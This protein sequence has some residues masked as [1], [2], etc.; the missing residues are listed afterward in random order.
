MHLRKLIVVFYAGKE[1]ICKELVVYN[2]RRIDVPS[3]KFWRLQSGFDSLNYELRSA[4]Y[5][6]IHYSMAYDMVAVTR[7]SPVAVTR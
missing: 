3:R 5:A 4:F 7:Y 2:F 6:L 1:Q